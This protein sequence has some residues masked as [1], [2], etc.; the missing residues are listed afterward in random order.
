MEAKNVINHDKHFK[1]EEYCAHVLL[2]AIPEDLLQ[3]YP[4]KINVFK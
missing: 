3:P 4:S 2:V 1:K